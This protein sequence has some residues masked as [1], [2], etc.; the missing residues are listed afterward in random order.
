[1]PGLQTDIEAG[2][3]ALLETMEEMIRKRG[4]FDLSI[5]D[6]ATE[7]GM[8]PSNIYRLFE[9][10]EALLEACAGRWFADKIAIMEEVSAADLP[11]REKLFQFFARRFRLMA[12]SYAAEPALFESYMELGDQHFEVIRGYVDLGDHYLSVIVTEAMEQGYFGDMSID[13]A[14]SLVNQM[15][16]PY[17]SPKI[18]TML[19][20]RLSEEKLS[21]IIDTIFIGLGKRLDDAGTA[22]DKPVMTIVS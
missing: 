10:R 12:E 20:P 3:T 4:A 5:T 18:L 6:L 11:V 17:I 16:A 8:S 22:S 9:S 7:A 13:H 21:Q 15:V 2:R 14:V 19:S 1:M